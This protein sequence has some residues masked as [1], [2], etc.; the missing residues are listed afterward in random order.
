[1]APTTPELV[2]PSLKMVGDRKGNV[3]IF[4]LR[5]GSVSL[6]WTGNNFVFSRLVHTNL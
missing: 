1:M 4:S 3:Y 6:E 5:V 2:L